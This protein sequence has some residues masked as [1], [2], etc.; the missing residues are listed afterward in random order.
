LHQNWN[1]NRFVYKEFARLVAIGTPAVNRLIEALQQ[2]GMDR[3][4]LKDRIIETLAAIGNPNAVEPLCALLCYYR[5]NESCAA[6]DATTH[7]LVKLQDPRGIE[8]IYWA[9]R[10]PNQVALV[11][12]AALVKIN[13]KR[14]LRELPNAF[15]HEDWRVRAEACKA[16]GAIAS[17]LGFGEPF[18]FE[19]LSKS[20]KSADQNV[21]DCAVRV[22]EKQASFRQA[23]EWKDAARVGNFEKW[24]QLHG[25]A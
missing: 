17:N 25:V 21:R 9:L 8:A 10:Q 14:T 24:R 4:W 16:F 6:H 1:Y 22:I 5:G 11:P 20:I 18:V 19:L 15:R 2:S 13:D 3:S 12:A 7:A 23:E